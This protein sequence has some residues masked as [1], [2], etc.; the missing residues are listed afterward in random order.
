MLTAAGAANATGIRIRH[1]RR[2]PRHDAADARRRRWQPPATP[3]SCARQLRQPRS[4]GSRRTRAQRQ[5]RC[6][7]RSWTRTEGTASRAWA[8]VPALAH[9]T[10]RVYSFGSAPGYHRGPSRTAGPL[11]SMATSWCLAR[12][13]G[14]STQSPSSTTASRTSPTRTATPAGREGRCSPPIPSGPTAPSAAD[15]VRR[16]PVRERRPRGRRRS[17]ARA[18]GSSARP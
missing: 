16:S 18:A 15:A 5:A 3:D 4:D 7:R 13:T 1:E 11:A 2:A 17:R 10:Q 12:A 14:W 8:A 6:H 9:I